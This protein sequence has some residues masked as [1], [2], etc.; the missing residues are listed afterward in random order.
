MLMEDILQLLNASHQNGETPLPVEVPDLSDSTIATLQAQ[1]IDLEAPGKILQDMDV[2]LRHLQEG[3]PVS[4]IQQ[5]IALKLLPT[6][7]EDL[8]L[9]IFPNLQRP[10]QKSYAQIHG[11][12]LLLRASGL[13]SITAKGKKTYW[14]INP[15]ILAAYRKLSPVEQYFNLLEIWLIRAD[16]SIL[17]ERS[18]DWMN[19]TRILN[20]WKLAMIDKNPYGNNPDHLSFSPGFH[21]VALMKL[22]GLIAVTS[23]SPAKTSA[24][25]SAKTKSWDIKSIAPTPWGYAV[26]ELFDRATRQRAWNWTFYSDKSCPIGE[27]QPALQ[28]YF[29]DWKNS[30]PLPEVLKSPGMRTF[31]V[32]LNKIWRRIAISPDCNL[33]DLADAIL[34]SV[35][36]DRDHLYQFTYPDLMGRLVD[37]CHPYME[38]SDLSTDE[39]EVLELPLAIGKS[40]EFLFDFGDC[41]RF[42]VTLESIDEDD[43]RSQHID[44]LESHGK[45]PEQ[46]GRYNDD[47]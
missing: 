46:Y 10:Q 33:T 35:D 45:D 19:R 47:D 14:I 27:L 31:R 24:K 11:L 13:T 28:P 40:M 8:S 1:C 12:Y 32:A 7:N 42:T 18:L 16:D 5:T 6:L 15:E 37:V 17:G 22:F 9:S 20:Y 30:L 23:K 21:H 34:T 4:D 38:E 43:H 2:M 29:P 25:S 39:V 44:I 3:I 41:W 26:L 36:F